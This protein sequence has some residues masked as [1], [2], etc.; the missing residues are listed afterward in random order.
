VNERERKT[1]QKALFC[2]FR[3]FFSFHWF[4][5]PIPLKNKSVEIRFIPN[6]SRNG[7]F[8][9]FSFLS[10]LQ[11]KGTGRAKIFAWGLLGDL[12]LIRSSLLVLLSFLSFD[13]IAHNIRR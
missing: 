13:K 1:K 12:L 3:A 9:V 8:G 2:L 11:P 4:K 6:A 7:F 5:M 10:L